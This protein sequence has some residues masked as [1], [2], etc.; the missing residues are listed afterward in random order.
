MH[1][2]STSVDRT[3]VTRTVIAA[4]GNRFERRSR[5]TRTVFLLEDESAFLPR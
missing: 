4:E 5:K 2:A 1:L 3:D